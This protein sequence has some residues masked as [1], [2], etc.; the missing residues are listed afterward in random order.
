ML[1]AATSCLAQNSVS[2][3]EA[4]PICI[5]GHHVLSFLL[6]LLFSGTVLNQRNSSIYNVFQGVYRELF[7]AIVKNCGL[8][9]EHASVPLLAVSDLGFVRVFT[10]SRASNYYSLDQLHQLILKTPTNS[11]KCIISALCCSLYTLWCLI[12]LYLFILRF[13]T[14]F[15]A[16]MFIT[17]NI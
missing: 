11:F 1:N 2:S 6:L 7:K 12:G 17:D 4:F 13:K 16:N 9:S 5:L 14:T 3:F 8:A 15:I 10:I